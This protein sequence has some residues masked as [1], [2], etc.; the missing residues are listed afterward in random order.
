MHTLKVKYFIFGG[1][2]PQDGVNKKLY[3]QVSEL[4][5]LGL[6]VELVIVG[7]GDVHYPSYDFLTTYKVDAVSAGDVFGRLGRIRRINRIFAETIGVLGPHDVLY[8]RY[9]APFLPYF[10]SKYLRR[11]RTCRIVT[12]HQTKELDE[13]KLNGDTLSYWSEYFFGMLLRRQA[14]AVIGVTDE[15]TR[16]EVARAR[17][18]EKTHLTIGNGFAVQSV[19][20]KCAPHHSGTDFHLL[21]VAN[22]SRW[23]GLD[24]L[25]QGLARYNGMSEVLL[26]IAGDGAELPYLR[27]LANDLGISDQV[28]F[29]G[30]LTGE[31]LN[32]LFNRCHVAVGS[33][34][35]HRLGLQEA[36]ILKARDYCA[37]GIPFI[38]G[39]SDP[40]F[41]TDFPYVLHLPA[42]ESPIDIERVLAFGQEICADPDHPQKMRRYAEERLDWS[43]KMRILKGFLEKL[44]GE[45]EGNSVPETDGSPYAAGE[46]G[47][48]GGA[49][50]GAGK[51]G[52]SSGGLRERGS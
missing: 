5:R 23:H 2:N 44:V 31:A 50:S 46:T 12:E 14:D 47:V 13:F 10:P 43:V 28:V 49:A 20:V 17:D 18:P 24:R 6:D 27:K 39:T 16:Y 29:H 42:D 51:G 30:F 26:H 21:C 1:Q 32:A 9:S 52:L 8:Y 25:F 19:P 38:Y 35:A 11:F 37:R 22:V 34:G 48:P 40:D 3:S 15:I 4:N 45:H 36:S 7:I 33:L 41:P